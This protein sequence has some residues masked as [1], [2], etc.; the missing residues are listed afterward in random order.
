MQTKP[1][2]IVFKIN[3]YISIQK[4]GLNGLQTKKKGKYNET[5]D[6]NPKEIR[7]KIKQNQKGKGNKIASSHT[8]KR[9]K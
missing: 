2:K 7:E 5:K 6:S 1:K 4:V 9:K 3:Q 8:H